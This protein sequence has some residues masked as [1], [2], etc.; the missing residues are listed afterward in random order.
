M[1]IHSL[2]DCRHP[3]TGNEYYTSLNSS[4]TQKA[5]GHMFPEWMNEWIHEWT[6]TN[7]WRSQPIHYRWIC[8][9]GDFQRQCAQC[10]GSFALFPPELG[11]KRRNRNFP[12]WMAIGK[13]RHGE[14][15][16]SQRVSAHAPDAL[17]PYPEGKGHSIPGGINWPGRG[18][19][20]VV[21]H[22]QEAAAA[23]GRKWYPTNIC[24]PSVAR[25]QR[26]LP[27]PPASNASTPCA[28]PR[29]LCG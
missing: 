26:M 15:L 9:L 14:W 24:I 23:A 21:I 8:L 22:M 4:S 17:D 12:E 27:Y 2:V 7:E 6:W 18:A 28:T 13:G 10:D 29:V 16:C 3:G 1:C 19:C 11:L 5:F 20:P 25:P